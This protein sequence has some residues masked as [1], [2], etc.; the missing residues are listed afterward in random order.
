[1]QHTCGVDNGIVR[2][3]ILGPLVVYLDGT[4][5]HARSVR[6]SLG[7]RGLVAPIPR[8]TGKMT[9]MS[10]KTWTLSTDVSRDSMQAALKELGLE[11]LLVSYPGSGYYTGASVAMVGPDHDMP[12]Y[13]LV[14]LR[15][16]FRER[17]D[18]ADWY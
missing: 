4:Q 5:A 11:R 2:F 8:T 16:Y 1:M 17:G 18:R 9:G 15:T 6:A 10:E 14:R 13:D 7:L 3:N 12:P